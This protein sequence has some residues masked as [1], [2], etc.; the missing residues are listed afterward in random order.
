MCECG[1]IHK[2]GPFSG[3]NDFDAFLATL[4]AAPSLSLVPVKV[5]HS[6]VGLQENWYQCSKCQAVWRLVE[7]DPPFTGLWE[8]VT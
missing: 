6:N 8:Q 7:P 4:K 5:P 3:W 2:P 1:S